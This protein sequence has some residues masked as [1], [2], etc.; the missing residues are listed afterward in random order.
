MLATQTFIHALFEDEI[1]TRLILDKLSNLEDSINIAEE[2]ENAL[3]QVKT[4]RKGWSVNQ[5]CNTNSSVD[6]VKVNTKKI[7]NSVKGNDS[8]IRK[9]YICGDLSHLA[10]VCKFRREVSNTVGERRMNQPETRFQ[11]K[12]VGK[13]VDTGGTVKQ[14]MTDSKVG[15]GNGRAVN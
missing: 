12:F 5:I 10:N 1:K 2:I 15:W 13:P 3:R 7:D 11:N 6:I 8:V 4:A 9:C 14:R